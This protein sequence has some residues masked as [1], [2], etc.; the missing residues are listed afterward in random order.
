MR[1]PGDVSV[2]GFDDMPEAA[3]CGLTSY[4]FDSPACARAMLN[5]ILQPP[6]GPTALRGRSIVRV[7]GR[8]SVRLTVGKAVT[9]H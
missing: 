8:L 6:R 9:H 2:V 7:P 1:V 3:R 5:H 4:N